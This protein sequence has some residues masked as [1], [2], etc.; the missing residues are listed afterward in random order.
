[1][2]A[3]R[4]FRRG[5]SPRLEPAGDPPPEHHHQGDH[6]AQEKREGKKEENRLLEPEDRVE[7]IVQDGADDRGDEEERRQP[8]AA[9]EF[10]E[11]H[12]FGG[13]SGSPHTFALT[14]E[15]RSYMYRLIES[16]FTP[17]AT[18]SP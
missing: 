7:E 8:G 13:G 5:S 1:M 9:E 16:S 3:G 17:I 2:V 10:P 18:G 12:A 4:G 11:L 15:N 14:S 6:R